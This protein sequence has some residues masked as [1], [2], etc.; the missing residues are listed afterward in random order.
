MG[1]IKNVSAAGFLILSFLPAG[2]AAAQT[3]RERRAATNPRAVDVR[4]EESTSLTGLYRI[5][6]AESDALYSVVADASSNLPYREQQ[7]FFIDLA[8]RLTPPDQFSI[9]QRGR[10]ISIASS[11][12]P[13]INFEADGIAHAERAAGGSRVLTRAALEGRRL[14]VSTDGGSEDK[15]SVSFEPSDGGRKLVVIRRI[16]T[17]GLNE[18]VIIRSVYDR[19]SEVAHWGIYGEPEVTSPPT[20]PVLAAD[21]SE[22]GRATTAVAESVRVGNSGAA[23]ADMDDLSRSFTEWIAATNQRDLARHLSFYAPRLKAFYLARDVSRESV[24][25]ERARA[26]EAA[27][28]LRVRAMEPET[29]LLDEGR[30][31]VM[32]FRKQYESGARGRKRSGEV[33]QEL[34]WRRTDR[35]WK[36]FSERDVRVLR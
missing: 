2:E 22:S 16:Y 27:G 13:R 25:I 1:V 8:V 11:R 26:F 12:A 30:V 7:R 5:D 35:G 32:R 28:P 36:I 17:Q 3:T 19:I 24:K 9:E 4:R 21:V 31:A 18:P 6:P 33:I 34:R 20:R 15:F 10:Q 23:R 29:V 14:M